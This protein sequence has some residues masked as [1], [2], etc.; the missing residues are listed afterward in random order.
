METREQARDTIYRELQGG[1]GEVRAEYIKHFESEMREFS[2][3]MA[4][5]VLAWQALDGE[6]KGDE[7]RAVVS[8]L[9]Y[10]AFTLHIISFKLFIAGLM[11]PAGNTFRQV[12][13]SI[14]VAL[15][16]SGR[17]LNELERFINDQYSPN[18]AVGD[19]LRH[20]KTL[21]L[22]KGRVDRIRICA[23]FLP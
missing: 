12:V 14:A 21:E 7:R 19:V 11:V 20:A 13:E 10:A 17:D 16:C 5:A 3:G 1:D 18:H 22:K 4:D 15:L 9:V 6:V 8:N 23:E 2:E